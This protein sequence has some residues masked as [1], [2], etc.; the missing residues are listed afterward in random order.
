MATEIT[1]TFTY[2]IPDEYLAQTNSNGDTATA[3]YTGPD[4]LYVLSL[5]H[6]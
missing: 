6:I 4:K 3:T 2:D 1:K 5:I